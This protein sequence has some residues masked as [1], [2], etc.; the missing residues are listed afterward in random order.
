MA[1][2]LIVA[3]EALLIQV[4]DGGSPEVFTHPCLI[5][6]TRGITWTTNVTE[7]Q[8]ADCAV[9]SN[10][11]KIVRKAQTIDFSIDGAGKVDATSVLGYINWWKSGLAKNIKINQ[12]LTGAAGGWTGT[13]SAILKDF[14]ITGDRGDYQDVKLTIVPAAVFTW[15]AN[16]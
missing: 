14:A 16:A 12:N 11:A 4:G 15:A 3:G 9:P 13:G 7:T 5:N 1:D 8:V 10:P 2:V 6:T